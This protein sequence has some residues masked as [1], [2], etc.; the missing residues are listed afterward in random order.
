MVFSL[1]LISPWEVGHQFLGTSGLLCVCG[2]SEHQQLEGS[3]LPKMQVLALE[4]NLV[5]VGLVKG[6]EGR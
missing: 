6:P 3:P 2:W 1:T 4:A 5:G